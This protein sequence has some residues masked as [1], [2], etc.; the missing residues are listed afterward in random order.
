MRQQHT[1]EPPC[2]RPAT[3][4]TTAQAPS[5]DNG[6]EPTHCPW[7][8]L[9]GV[10]FDESDPPSDYC[11][12]DPA[13]V[14]PSPA[15]DNV[16]TIGHTAPPGFGPATE[17]MGTATRPTAASAHLFPPTVT[18]NEETAHRHLTLWLNPDVVGGV[19]CE[20]EVWWNDSDP[21]SDPPNVVHMGPLHRLAGTLVRHGYTADE[22]GWI[23]ALG[24]A[25]AP[26][27]LLAHEAMG[28]AA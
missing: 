4:P 11:G 6:T 18:G 9:Y 7:C 12:H 14:R 23:L 25:P 19:S 1:L 13:L 24:N 10:G 5:P 26:L 3:A 28:D 21:T 2:A 27:I 17:A 16:G 22:V 20:L 15:P 8:G